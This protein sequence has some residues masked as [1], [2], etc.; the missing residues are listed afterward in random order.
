MSL[1]AGTNVV[2]FGTLSEGD[3]NGD[4][5]VGDADFHFV[6][7]RFGLRSGESGFDTAADLTGDGVVDVADLSLLAGNFGARGPAR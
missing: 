7:G 5:E 1:A 6:A 2:Q 4:D 3:A